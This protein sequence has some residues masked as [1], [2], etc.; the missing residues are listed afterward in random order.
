MR[1]RRCIRYNCDF[2]S[3]GMFQKPAMERHEKYCLKN[4]YRKCRTCEFHG[5]MHEHPIPELVT[6]LETGGM[7]AL[8]DKAEGCPTCILAGIVNQRAV[9]RWSERI[10]NDTLMEMLGFN[11]KEEADKFYRA[12]RESRPEDFF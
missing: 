9:D 2:C 5:D 8:R 12:V 6:A 4:P 1:S 10:G 7:L 11:H 3:K